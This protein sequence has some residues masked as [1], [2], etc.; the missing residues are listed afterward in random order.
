MA[1]E[2]QA[3]RAPT[4]AHVKLGRD[5]H[6]VVHVQADAL[7]GLYWGMG[8]SHALDRSLQLVLMRILG[9][10]RAAELLEG[11]DEMVE[12]DR[13]F[14]RMNWAGHVGQELAALDEQ[15]RALVE[16][17]CEGLNARLSAKRP[18]ELRLIGVRFEPWTAGDCLLLSRMMGYLTLAQSQAEVERL[19]VEMV[20][21]GIDD[22]R[23][24]ELFPEG[25][26]LVGR[27]RLAELSLGERIVPEGLRWL[28]PAPRMMAS[29]NWV[30]HPDKTR[31]G[32]A[33]MAND[34]HLEVNRLPAVWYELAL[35]TPEQSFVGAT[36]PGLPAPLIGRTRELSWGAT[37]TFMDASDSWVE[38][39]REGKRRVGDE[40]VD[41]ERR[42]E[43]IVRRGR[44]PITLVIH[45][46]EAHGV[47]DGDPSVPGLYLS[48]RWASARSGGR[49]LVVA[50]KMWSAAT[51]SEAL[52]RLGELETAWNW[53]VADR[54][55][56]IGYAMSGLAP[57]RHGDWRGFAPAPGWLPEYDW[58]GF[59]PAGEL[60]RVIDPPEGYIVTANQ[61]L[62]HLGLADPINMP[63]GDYRARRIAS[64][65]AASDE[66]DH[67]SLAAIQMDLHSIPAEAFMAILEPLLPAE[68]AA[69][70]ALRGWDRRYNVDSRGA[71]VF[72]DFYAALIREIFGGEGGFGPEVLRHLQD[73]TG[74]FIDFYQQC[75]RVLLAESSSWFGER[76][77][78]Q[79]FEDAFAAIA[80]RTAPARGERNQVTLTNMFFAGKLPRVLGFDRGPYPLPGGRAT[81]HQGQVYSSGGRVTSFAPSIRVI[82]DM[83]DDELW[84][85]L[86]G[87]PS[88]R[89][90]SRW[91]ASEVQRWLAGEYKQ[92]QL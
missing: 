64:L 3:L 68:G 74:V 59:V 7:S 34:P 33:M 58:Q 56:H 44:E 43:L 55:G 16:A 67:R 66:H 10:G 85:S 76:S 28:S 80:E 2:L 26:E 35:R 86:I 8:Y 4:P 40:W 1:P 52:G 29:N 69:A 17:Y 18:W 27:E 9:Q 45:E 49:S 21:A 89:R 65:L 48:R 79:L 77:R 37:Y 13:F 32:A 62:N 53:V 61:D 31:S 20:Q 24:A 47:L 88:D 11:S 60:P 38:E 5:E 54:E 39:C 70:E 81:P 14:R 15:T 51:V 46:S 50:S 84:T 90:F 73:H 23:L 71:A 30:V 19:F 25:C 78:E 57:R 92:L 6:G 22:D 91:Y 12:I 36:I 83:A 42:E 72:E 75:D 41:F 87:G 63:M 82:A